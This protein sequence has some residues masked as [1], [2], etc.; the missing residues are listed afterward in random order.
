[1]CLNVLLC[2]GRR[3]FPAISKPILMLGINVTLTSSSFSL[4]CLKILTLT[5][6]LFFAVIQWISSVG[7]RQLAD[8]LKCCLISLRPSCIPAGNMCRAQHHALWNTLRAMSC[9]STWRGQRHQRGM[10]AA[11]S[12]SSVLCLTRKLVW[13][14]CLYASDVVGHT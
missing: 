3:K 5:K 13:L 14:W 2:G 6:S 12:S 11:W 8:I 1:M 4:S 9:V 10:A 7:W